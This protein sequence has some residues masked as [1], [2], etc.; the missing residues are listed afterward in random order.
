M[1]RRQRN[2][3]LRRDPQAAREGTQQGEIKVAA[4]EGGV[5]EPNEFDEF[6]RRQER[7][8]RR[9][10]I[11][12]RVMDVLTVRLA[13]LMVSWQCANAGADRLACRA[14]GVADAWFRSVRSVLAAPG[15]ERR[16]ASQVM[17]GTATCQTVLQE[18]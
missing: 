2:D 14:A 17:D 12:T 11:A 7:Q 13:V 5:T 1:G 15:R 18:S 10:L 9:R 6:R 16:W 4:R 8:E 3:A